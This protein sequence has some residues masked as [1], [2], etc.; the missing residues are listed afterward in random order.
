[1]RPGRG[2]DVFD[3]LRPSQVEVVCFERSW[4]LYPATAYEWL[5][6]LGH[7]LDTFAGVVP[8]AVVDAD[9]DAMFQLGLQ[10]DDRDRRWVNA[11]R[12]AVGRAGGRD[13]WWVAN[14]SKRCLQGWAYIHGKLL[15]EGVN[16]RRLPFAD[17]LDAAYMMMWLNQDEK[18]RMKFDAEL[19]MVP[20]GATVARTPAQVQA[21]AEAFAAD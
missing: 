3:R 13:W 5:G 11:A 4:H 1:M 14:L 20:A 10:Y 16:A 9:V 12:V 6:V 8:G 19:S 21:M 2:V 7:D 15:L 17:W 18:G